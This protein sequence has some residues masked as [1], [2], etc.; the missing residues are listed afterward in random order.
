VFKEQNDAEH[1]G[2]WWIAKRE[3]KEE[4]KEKWTGVDSLKPHGQ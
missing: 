2:V 3:L 4:E 1:V